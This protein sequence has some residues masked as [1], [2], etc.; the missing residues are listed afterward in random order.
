M[1][2]S[3]ERFIQFMENKYLSNQLPE[4]WDDLSHAPKKMNGI[5]GYN[6]AC[7]LGISTFGHCMLSSKSYFQFV[8]AFFR[9]AVSSD[10]PYL[11][12]VGV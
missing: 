9:L 10:L 6:E 11:L 8:I 12:P 1:H 3:D 4:W 5:I 7:T 2:T